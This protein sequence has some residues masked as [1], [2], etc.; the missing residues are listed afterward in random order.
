MDFEALEE[1][2]QSE[3]ELLRPMLLGYAETQ[4][5]AVANAGSVSEK[6]DALVR[7]EILRLSHHQCVAGNL[8]SHLLAR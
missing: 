7:A 3:L 8:R 5:Q 4:H 1:Q 2:V 6:R